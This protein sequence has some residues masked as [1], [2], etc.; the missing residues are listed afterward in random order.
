MRLHQIKE[1]LQDRL[2][3]STGKPVGDIDLSPV[4]GGSINETYRVKVDNAG[5]YFLKLNS[6][7]SYPQLFEKEKNGLE[8]LGRQTVIRTP[9]VIF[10]DTFENSQLLLLE[11]IEPG[12][13]TPIFWEE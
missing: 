12:V 1:L 13:R 5:N 11:W 6:S 7:K 2:S 10:C 3:I 4:G 8:Y 9:I